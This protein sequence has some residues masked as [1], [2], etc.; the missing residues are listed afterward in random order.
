MTAQQ[1]SLTLKAER[2]L[3]IKYNWLDHEQFLRPTAF[4]SDEV[5]AF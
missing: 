3:L 1:Y 2:L 5:R 4:T